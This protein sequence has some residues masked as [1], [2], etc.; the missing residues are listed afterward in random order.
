MTVTILYICTLVFIGLREY[1]ISQERKQWQVE[2]KD[3]LDRIQANDFTEYKVMTEPSKPKEKE[4]KKQPL[5][6]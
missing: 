1:Y 3:L 5:F 4:D 2:R 6:I